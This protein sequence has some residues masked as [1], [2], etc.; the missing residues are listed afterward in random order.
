MSVAC[1]RSWVSDAD[2]RSVMNKGRHDDQPR[3]RPPPSAPA[4]GCSSTGTGL[5]RVP[6]RAVLSALAGG[7]LTAASLGGPLAG[8]A[9]GAEGTTGATTTE[10]T[11][12]PVSTTPD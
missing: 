6:W 11:P 2:Q 3:K 7:G 10:G 5:R 1:P 9:L 8:G 12:P 4:D